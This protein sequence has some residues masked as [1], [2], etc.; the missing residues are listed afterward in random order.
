[1]KTYEDLAYQAG[2]ELR[3]RGDEDMVLPLIFS[4]VVESQRPAGG[5]VVG[6]GSRP[7]GTLLAVILF[8]F[9]LLSVSIH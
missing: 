9:F 4:V 7:L 2:R 8:F 5:R 1:L 3:E 6:I